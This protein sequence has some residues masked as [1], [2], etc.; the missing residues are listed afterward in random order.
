MDFIFV[1]PA[2]D[3]AEECYRALQAADQL[4]GRKPD[5]TTVEAFVSVPSKALPDGCVA[6]DGT[7][8]HAY[9]YGRETGR[10]E[11]TTKFVPLRNGSVDRASLDRLIRLLPLTRAQLARGGDL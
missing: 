7:L 5:A 6:K 3:T 9:K 8:A 1:D 4:A 10:D 2:V 11:V